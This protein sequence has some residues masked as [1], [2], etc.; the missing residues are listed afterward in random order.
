[1]RVSAADKLTIVRD[2][3][4]AIDPTKSGR[5]GVALE[6]LGAGKAREAM[7]Q[8]I[9]NDSRFAQK[10]FN[11]AVAGYFYQSTLSLPNIMSPVKNL[12]QTLTATAPRIGMK[13]TVEGIKTTMKGAEMYSTLRFSG[14]D[15]AD[16]FAKA[17]PGFRETGLAMDEGLL[18]A[19]D[20]IHAGVTSEKNITVALR[21]AKQIGMSAFSASEMSNRLIAYY[22]GRSAATAMYRKMAELG[23]EVDDFVTG[24][25]MLLP[26]VQKAFNESH[27]V[28]ELIHGVATAVVHDTQGGGGVAT[29]PAVLAKVPPI[30]RQ[31]MQFP[32]RYASQLLHGGAG[33]LGRALVAGGVAA[34]ALGA[35]F[36]TAGKKLAN[37]ATLFGAMPMPSDQGPFAPFPLVP[38]VL[39]LA[40]SG[41]QALATGDPTNLQRSLPLLVPGG[42]GFSRIASIT[43]KAEIANFL[44]KPSA[45]YSRTTPDGRV[46]M[47]DKHGALIGFYTPTQLFAKSIGLG[48]VNAEQEL[49][50]NQWMEKYGQRTASMRQEYLTAL[51]SGDVRKAQSIDRDYRRLNPGVGGLPIKP[52]HLQA[53]AARRDVS[54]LERQLETLPPEL[55]GQFSAVSAISFGQ[56]GPG[57]LGIPTDA[58]TQYGTMKSRNPYRLQP[59]SGDIVGAGVQRVDTMLGNST[60]GAY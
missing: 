8:G 13:H 12:F 11:T 55:R 15:H 33:E 32:I 23:V 44:G 37:D 35:I 36:G 6:T 43:G 27:R 17:F 20:K 59:P 16:A 47:M 29:I 7:V 42:V 4:G 2:A 1:M 53:L 60:L 38:P 49:A 50:L 21:K 34:G 48:D 25:K 51:Q 40:G 26:K 14:I 24:G 9:L 58:L 45:D 56:S 5:L 52:Q 46:P 22:G 10:P 19:M 30:F 57:F 28:Q 39:Q 31:L 3:S 18:R 54:R 41:A